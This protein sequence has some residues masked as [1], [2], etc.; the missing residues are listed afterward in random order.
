M[1]IDFAPEKSLFSL[2]IVQWSSG[3]TFLLAIISTVIIA[4][5]MVGTPWDFT[6]SGF[7]N[8]AVAYKVPAAFLAIGFT[9]V[10]LCGANHRSEQSRAQMK[11]TESQNIF[12]NH[13]KHIEE[14]E[15]YCAAICKRYTDDS[16]AI[17]DR[18]KKD[19]YLTELIDSIRIYPHID[20]RYART[21]YVQIFPESKDGNFKISEN[22][23]RDLDDSIIKVASK[24]NKLAEISKIKNVENI[25]NAIIDVYDEINEFS[26]MFFIANPDDGKGHNF[27]IGNRG[28]HI[29][30][31]DFSF[32]NRKF[33]D[34]ICAISMTL[35]F[36]VSHKES[37]VVRE[38]LNVD[39]D[40]SEEYETKNNLLTINWDKL[41]IYL[42][43]SLDEKESVNT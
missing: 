13:Y 33:S 38:I 5:N 9:I 14:F 31:N 40:E 17:K 8:F 29:P 7:N 27:S 28:A 21:I 25:R 24:F 4:T 32:L 35:M 39:L 10:G 22:F 20:L 6:G 1:K 36:D 18:Y 12:S 34:Y 41:N 15:K 19:K 42:A 43:L 11:L 30:H 3:A 23:L 26:D 16:N 2:P 37:K